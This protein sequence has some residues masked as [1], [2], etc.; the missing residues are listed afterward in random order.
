LD[1]YDLIN[2]VNFMD[3]LHQLLNLDGKILI[4][5]VKLLENINL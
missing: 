1:H 5:L 3:L 4:L 2:Q